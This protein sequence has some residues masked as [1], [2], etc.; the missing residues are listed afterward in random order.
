MVSIT[1]NPIIGYLIGQETPM[2]RVYIN[3]TSWK[4]DNLEAMLDSIIFYCLLIA[5]MINL[6]VGILR[7]SFNNRKN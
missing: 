6:V 2:I 1:M 4:M 7:D 5:G 3:F